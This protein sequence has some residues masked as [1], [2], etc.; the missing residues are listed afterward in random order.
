METHA[1]M[2]FA[3]FILDRGGF[4]EKCLGM[5]ELPDGGVG[6]MDVMGR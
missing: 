3:L 6:I 1:I 5:Q 4:P 2:W